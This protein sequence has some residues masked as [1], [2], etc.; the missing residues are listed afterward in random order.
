MP[1]P[2]PPRL[3]AFPNSNLAHTKPKR[4][5]DSQIRLTQPLLA[6]NTTPDI[7]S[8]CAS[9]DSETTPL[10]PV[11]D[12]THG[13][14]SWLQPPQMEKKYWRSVEVGSVVTFDMELAAGKM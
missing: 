4:K 12:Q 6:N 2:P 10:T 1:C 5:A 14:E 13:W 9:V 3:H 7:V 11:A 8:S